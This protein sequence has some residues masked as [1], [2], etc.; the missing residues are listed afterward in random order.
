VSGASSA[1]AAPSVGAAAPASAVRRVAVVG[2]SVR[3]TCGVRD[4]GTL[5]AQELAREGLESSL[6]W[7][8]REQPALRAARAETR[9][10]ARA[11][12][13][14]LERLRPDAAVLHYSAFSYSY[15]G[16]PLLLPPVLGALRRAGVPVLS[17]MHEL[18]YPWGRSGWRGA[19]WGITQRAYLVELVRASDAV[20][21]TADFQAR[22]LQSRAWLP[23]RPLRVAPV[24]SNL[25][26]P[27]ELAARG[28]GGPVLGV[29]GYAY[30]GAAM[31]LVLDALALLARGGGDLRLALLGAPGRDSA[32]AQE[33]LSAARARGVAERV[34]VAGP[35][36]AQELSDALARCDVLVFPD[37]GGPSSRKGSL[38]G[39]LASGAPLV[40]LEGPRMWPELRAAGALEIVPPDAAALAETLRELL[41]D[42]PRRRALGARGRAFAE[43]RMGLAHTAREV[44]ALLAEMPRGGQAPAASA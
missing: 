27:H 7:L 28:E 2:I 24:Y 8:T 9:T 21:V 11:L 14:E 29:F 16:V 5:L 12:S 17:V 3:R 39:A 20:L 10:W 30:Q 41:A 26:P 38:A 4:H 32:V 22:W 19:V 25:P 40:A 13:G 35:L 37:Q 1:P 44:L 6:H 33:L 34:S 23:A 43:T 36:P 15:R 42:E 18:A 31:P